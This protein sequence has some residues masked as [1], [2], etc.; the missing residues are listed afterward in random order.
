M[1]VLTVPYI[2]IY[3]SIWGCFIYVRSSEFFF[4]P[5]SA[6]EEY[7]DRS[8]IGLRTSVWA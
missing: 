5:P 2:I 1:Q 3:H 6:E 8:V 7:S 4:I